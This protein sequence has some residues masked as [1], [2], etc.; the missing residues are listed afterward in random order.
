VSAIGPS[1]EGMLVSF[2]KIDAHGTRWRLELHRQ[3]DAVAAAHAAQADDDVAVER[4][5]A[6]AATARLPA[7]RAAIPASTTSPP[8]TPAPRPRCGDAAEVARGGRAWHAVRRSCMACGAAFVIG[9]LSQAPSTAPA[10]GS[11]HVLT[12]RH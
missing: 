2:P 3:G 6:G 4:I 10:V 11:A 9:R 8:T 12:H 5:A 1:K 7:R